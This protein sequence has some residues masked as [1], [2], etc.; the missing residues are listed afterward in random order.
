M[1]NQSFLS[2]VREIEGIACIPWD[3]Y[4][5]KTIF[6]TGGTGLIGTT[7]IYGVDYANNVRDL[8]I[9]I[10]AL[11]RDL[12]K[13]KER[14]QYL[15][16]KDMV[17]FVVGNVENIPE[18][19]DPIDFIVHG[20]S[21]TASKEFINHAVET[22]RTSVFGTTQV[23][24]L[25]KKKG[26]KLVYLSSMEVYG[27]PEKGHKLIESEI[28]ALS[29]LD[30]R[31]SYPLGKIMSESLCC[32]YA[33]EYGVDT[34]I[35]RLAQTI[36]AGISEKDKRVFAYFSECVRDG[37]NIVLKTRG[38]AERCYLHA[39]DAVSAILVCLVKGV[40]GHAYNAADEETYCSIAEMAQKIASANGI[41]V[42]YDL[43]DEKAN[44]FPKTVY[45]KLDTN[46]LKEL[47]WQP[48]GRTQYLQ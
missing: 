47:G 48:N 1:L 2:D 8:K 27:F 18:I 43:Q 17:Q 21:Q 24:D 42:E 33:K 45:L 25:A 36:G 32:A 46:A 13:A 10:I 37:K 28:G 11:V 40:A 20:A 34:K 44:G 26:A 16:K 5:K 39:N 38:E 35:I 9:K 29:P 22:I 12:E 4:R 3:K 15:L 6:V 31:N 14:F 30:L 7:L 23:L 19:E 41:K